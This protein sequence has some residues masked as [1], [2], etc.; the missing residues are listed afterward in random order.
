MKIRASKP[1]EDGTIRYSF[2]C[3]A[4]KYPHSYLVG[5]PPNTHPRWSFNGDMERPT[6][7]PSLLM[8]SNKPGTGERLVDCHLFL[9][10]GVI[11]FCGDNPHELN[12]KHVPLAE[13][14]PEWA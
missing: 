4:C 6:F 7:G 1:G 2:F 9:T 14:P 13:F 12:G 11:Q 3:P 10:D 5:G 8:Y